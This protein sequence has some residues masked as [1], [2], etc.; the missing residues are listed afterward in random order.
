MQFSLSTVCALILSCSMV[1]SKVI[2]QC[3]N[4]GMFAMTFDDGPAA[5]TAELLSI[6]RQKNAKITFHLTTTYLTDPNTQSM[7]KQIANDGHLIGLRSEASWNL[8]SMSNEQIKAGLARQGNVLANFIGYYPK[9]AVL[10]YGGYNQ[11][12]LDAVESTGLI[13]SSFNIDTYDY[14]NDGARTL[15]AVKLSLSLAGQGQGSFISVQHDGI[16]QS[17]AVTGQLIDIIRDSGYKLVKLD[18]CLGM[19]DMTKNK[20][21]L[22]GADGID[23]DLSSSPSANGGI[24]SNPGNSPSNPGP[25]ING[26]LKLQ[27]GASEMISMSGMAIFAASALASLYLF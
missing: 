19:S 9:F 4:S 17:V 15:N 27:N 26:R 13:V 6:L 23:M 1:S 14:A 20:V 8:L 22:I 18:E 12:T 11:N 10:P 16:K 5:H 25:N 3:V 21:P 2:T 24:V 7:I